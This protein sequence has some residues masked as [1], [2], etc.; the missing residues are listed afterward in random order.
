MADSEEPMEVVPTTDAGGETKEKS[1]S[2]KVETKTR[3]ELP[4]YAAIVFLV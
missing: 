1:K 4:W 3:H 2:V